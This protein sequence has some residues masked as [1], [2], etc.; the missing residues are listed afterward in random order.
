MPDPKKKYIRS[1][2]P[3]SRPGFLV[4]P[5]GFGGSLA[6][7]PTAAAPVTP[8]PAPLPSSDLDKLYKYLVSS[9][10]G[11]R[12]AW[13]RGINAIAYH[14]T[15]GTMD[16]T[17]IQLTP[18]GRN[19]AGRGLYQFET[20]AGSNEAR[21]AVNRAVQFYRTVLKEPVPAWVVKL[22]KQEGDIEFNKLPA[23]QQTALFIMNGVMK[24]GRFSD[25][26]GTQERITNYWLNHHWSGSAAKR[27]AEQ[28]KFNKSYGL[29][30]RSLESN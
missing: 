24:P 30:L 13:E 28:Q 23:E 2:V 4:S 3:P 18:T 27:P 19:G 11:S 14:E 17:T 12:E 29:Y 20:S 8:P 21:T 25:I 1:Y 26:L 7:L 16:P 10:G 6:S 5:T 9:R 15:G 22:N